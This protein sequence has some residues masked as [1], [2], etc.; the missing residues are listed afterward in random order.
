MGERRP[1]LRLHLA[2]AAALVA[3]WHVAH[4]FAP[5]AFPTFPTV[6]GAFLSQVRSGALP[7]ALAA[8]LF[9]IAAGYLLA[10]V[11][12][13][14]LGLAMGASDALEAALDPY[15]TAL[16]VTPFAA[17]VPALV[18][19]FGTG[20]GVRVAVVFLFA[21]FP[22]AI[23]TLEGAAAVPA[24]LVEAAESFGADRRF[25]LARVVLPHEATYV[26]AGLRLGAGRAVKGLVVTELL[27]SVTGFGAVIARWS[28]A[29]RI[30]GVLSVVAVLM[31][32]GVGATWLLG[33]LERRLLPWRERG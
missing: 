2:F 10:V 31:A 20:T 19:W 27:V 11:V 17:L 4:L 16:Y 18:V 24:D 1:H 28:S 32:L 15:L 6:A 21:V 30:E 12:G 3:G 29:F 23:N 33:A 7:A 8:A 25:V 14:P 13:V 9:A 22:V 26:L 5:A